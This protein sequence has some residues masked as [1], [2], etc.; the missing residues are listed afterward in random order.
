MHFAQNKIIEKYVKN[1]S[2]GEYH[3]VWYYECILSYLSVGTNFTMKSSKIVI[4]QAL[5][6]LHGVSKRINET[7]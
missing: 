6:S 2:W 4:L 5:E 7:I 1:T 3:I